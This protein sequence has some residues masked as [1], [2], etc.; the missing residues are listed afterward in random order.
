[1]VRS[2]V[3]L[4]VAIGL[5]AKW[6]TVGPDQ[7]FVSDI[8]AEVRTLVWLYRNPSMECRHVT[9]VT[10]SDNKRHR[11]THCYNHINVLWGGGK[12]QLYPIERL[13]SSSWPS[14]MLKCLKMSHRE[15]TPFGRQLRHV[16]IVCLKALKPRYYWICNAHKSSF[17]KVWN[18]KT[19][20]EDHNIINQKSSN[21]ASGVTYRQGLPSVSFK[22]SIPPGCC[23]TGYISVRNPS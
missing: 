13:F 7:Q 15:S 5:E 6:Q 16:E 23:Y 8:V 9:Y 3:R 22:T 4:I 10:L 18:M 17:A 11:S 14:D 19:F 1:M 2:L 20:N 21:S 12:R